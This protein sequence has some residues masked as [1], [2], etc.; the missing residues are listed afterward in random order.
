MLVKNNYNECLTNLACSIRKYFDLEYSHSTLS[1][2]DKILEESLPKNVVVILFDGMGSRILERTLNEESFFRK[3]K[4]KDIVTVFPATTTSATT[5]IRTGLNPIEHC[6]LGWYTYLKSI[7]KTITLFLNN[8]KG[9]NHACDA[10]LNIKEKFTP[11]TIVE[12]INE[13]KKHSAIELFPFGEDAYNGLDDMISRIKVETKKEGKKY[14]YAYDTEPD[15][16]MHEWGCDCDEVKELIKIRNEKIEKMCGELEDTLVIVIADHGH[17]NVDPIFL[18]EYPSLLKMMERTTSLEQRAVSFKIK[19]EFKSV[20]EKEFN[21]L[22]GEYFSLYS[23]DDVI[24]SGLFGDGIEHEMFDTAIG[25]YIAIAETSNKCLIAPDDNEILA[26]QH[27]GYTVDEIYV[28][29][30]IINK[31]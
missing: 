30:I 21:D 18:K 28:P 15:H 29:L 11:K 19:D 22:L 23:K 31:K 14:I 8:E 5:S 9:V 10:Y 4:L 16:S 3:N 24:A 6:W 25:D 1:Y 20:F 2:I 26:S 12:E 7:D 17:I 27:A 13:N